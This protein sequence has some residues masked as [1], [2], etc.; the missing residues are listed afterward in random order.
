MQ[1]V[2]QQRHRSAPRDDDPLDPGGDEEDDQADDHRPNARGAGL[3][4]VVHHARGVVRMGHDR[5][6]D[7]GEEL[8]GPGP[9]VV[10]LVV[11]VL[12]GTVAL[13]GTHGRLSRLR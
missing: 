1:G 9:M 2:A 12:V 6:A 5:V 11:V 7:R 8:G 4:L 10:G 13:M 3:D